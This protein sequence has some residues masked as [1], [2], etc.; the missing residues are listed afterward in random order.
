MTTAN[1]DTVPD[2]AA[3]G[4]IKG[5]DVVAGADVAAGCW[6]SSAARERNFMLCVDVG[7]FVADLGVV[8]FVRALGAFLL[9]RA[10]VESSWER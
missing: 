1:E 8:G 5:A 4:S 7:D 6:A 9:G 2:V 3:E 10:R